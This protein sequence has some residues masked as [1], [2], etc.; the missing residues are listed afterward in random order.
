MIAFAANSVLARLALGA[1]EIDPASYTTLRLLAG[2]LVLFMLARRDHAA[3]PSGGWFPA[4]ALFGYAAAFSFAYLNLATGT[5]ALI[6]FASVQATMIGWGLW[7]GD[8]PNAAEWSGLTIAFAAFTWLVSPGLAAPDPFSSGLMILAGLSWGAYSIIG[9]TFADPLQATAGN[10]LRAAPLGLA[11][12]VVFLAEMRISAQGAL[13]AVISGALT[14]GLGYALWY[15]ALKGISQVQAA[16]VQLTVP[17]IA[18]GGG[19]LFLS[20]PL[21]F[22]FALCSALI[23]GGIAIAVLSRRR[24]KA[25]V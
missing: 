23:L 11:L 1:G 24:A 21:T 6:L 14:S 7:K 4:L 22:R 18:A 15:R 20:E 13:L 9:R 2:A 12:S 8:R 17:A 16:L 5:G 25:A 3:R 19:I 10:F